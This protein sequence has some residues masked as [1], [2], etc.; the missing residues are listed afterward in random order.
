VINQVFLLS[1]PPPSMASAMPNCSQ[2]VPVT[3]PAAELV[4]WKFR[5]AMGRAFRL[6]NDALVSTLQPNSLPE[7][8]EPLAA[9]DHG[10]REVTAFFHALGPLAQIKHPRGEFEAQFAQVGRAAAF[11]DLDR[12]G[13]FVRMAGHAA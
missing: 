4:T 6:V 7:F 2:F 9:D 10:F 11:E 8:F 5:R 1:R 13:D 3:K 12:L